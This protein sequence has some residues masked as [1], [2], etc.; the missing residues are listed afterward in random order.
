MLTE[1]MK[2]VSI[3][4]QPPLPLK[5]KGNQ[6]GR[7]KIASPLP[8]GIENNNLLEK[9][10]GLSTGVLERYCLVLQILIKGFHVSDYYSHSY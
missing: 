9:T 4:V 8:E 7:E 5:R 3:F 6:R 2:K 10:R 1:K